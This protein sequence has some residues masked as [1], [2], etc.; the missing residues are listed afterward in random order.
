M[1][2]CVQMLQMLD[3]VIGADETPGHWQYLKHFVSGV[4]LGFPVRCS[5]TKFEYPLFAVRTLHCGGAILLSCMKECGNLLETHNLHCNIADM[6][7]Q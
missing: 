1:L 6:A 4:L 2:W 5:S 7:H 3:E